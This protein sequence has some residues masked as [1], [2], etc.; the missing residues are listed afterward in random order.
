VVV[1]TVVVVGAIPLVPS[2]GGGGVMEVVV[3][4]VMAMLMKRANVN[5]KMCDPSVPSQL[6]C[7]S[8]EDISSRFED[9]LTQSVFR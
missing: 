2:S 1:A 3:I 6:P 7:S 8:F 5:E 9:I 4:P